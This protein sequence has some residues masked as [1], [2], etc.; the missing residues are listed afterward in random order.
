VVL[1]VPVAA[2]TLRF[3]RDSSR[4]REIALSAEM[5]GPAQ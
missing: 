5:S 3:V 4:E 2:S 1:S